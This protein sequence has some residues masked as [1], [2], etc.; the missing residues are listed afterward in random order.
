MYV[1]FCRSS[2]IQRSSIVLVGFSD[3][4]IRGYSKSGQRVMSQLLHP[5]PVRR[6]TCM[7]ASPSLKHSTSLVTK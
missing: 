6:L 5:E 1:Y 4:Y 7:A 3:G 2:T